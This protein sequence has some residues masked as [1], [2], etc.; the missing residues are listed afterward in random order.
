MNHRF[1]HFGPVLAAT[2][3]DSTL[4]KELLDR[5]NKT[6]ES[7]V[8]HLAGHLETENKFTVDDMVWFVDNFGKYFE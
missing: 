4:L 8:Q 6:T 7:H 1:V 3:V 2:T 5:G